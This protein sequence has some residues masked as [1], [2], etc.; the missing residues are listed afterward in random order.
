MF[1]RCFLVHSKGI[2]PISSESESD[3]LSVKL[4]VQKP[5]AGLP[6]IFIYCSNVLPSEISF[7]RR[8]SCGARPLKPPCQSV[9]LFQDTV[10]ED[11]QILLQQQLQTSL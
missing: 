7:L 10:L 4:R 1:S 2:E 11:Y 5:E 9:K 6:D 3:A 8:C